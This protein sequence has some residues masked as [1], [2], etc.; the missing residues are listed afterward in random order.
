MY[1]LLF[2]SLSEIR[3]RLDAAFQLNVYT[4]WHVEEKKVL[5]EVM[6]IH[7]SGMNVFVF[8]M[9]ADC[10]MVP[11]FAPVSGKEGILFSFPIG[12]ECWK[13]CM[14]RWKKLCNKKT[15]LCVEVE[16]QENRYRIGFVLANEPSKFIVKP[17]LYEWQKTTDWINV[18]S[19]HPGVIIPSEWTS[20][21]TF[22]VPS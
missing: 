10:S 4:V 3:K 17:I 1:R 15:L 6:D 13:W 8:H 14:E 21:V 5:C 16:P 7:L 22:E 12:M 20:K 9:K 18:Y 19:R 2:Y 11:A